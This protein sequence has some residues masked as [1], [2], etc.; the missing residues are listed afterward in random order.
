MKWYHSVKIASQEED[1]EHIIGI[2]NNGGGEHTISQRVAA[3][4][5][6]AE[7]GDNS[8]ATGR[9]IDAI[10]MDGDP[11][12]KSAA[13]Q[14]LSIIL[15]K[16]N[17][18]Q[19]REEVFSVFCN[20]SKTVYPRQFADAMDAVIASFP[21]DLHLLTQ[22]FK[23]LLAQY[24]KG[25][26]GDAANSVV[27]GAMNK[28][29]KADESSMRGLDKQLTQPTQKETIAQWNKMKNELIPGT[30]LKLKPRDSNASSVFMATL[31]TIEYQPFMM[32]NEKKM[33]PTLVIDSGTGSVE[34]IGVLN[35]QYDIYVVKNIE[36]MSLDKYKGHWV[37]T[38][39]PVARAFM[40]KSGISKGILM[41]K[42][43]DVCTIKML[44][45][46]TAWLADVPCSTVKPSVEAPAWGGEWF[47]KGTKFSPGDVVKVNGDGEWG[48]Y[49]VVEVYTNRKVNARPIGSTSG[50]IVLPMSKLEYVGRIGLKG[51][52][53]RNSHFESEQLPKPLQEQDGEL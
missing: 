53:V 18:N 15:G 40:D 16:T 13:I 44:N 8:R 25:D 23:T 46:T 1:L 10:E 24:E 42:K 19:L 38:N 48:E 17:N 5:D 9:L 3:A 49:L 33:M 11:Q 32:G 31:K 47:S 7:F 22:Q 27:R 37:Q 21:D 41:K 26:A 20:I 52:V 29:I 36:E 39:D 12:V 28:V 50:G 34:R 51:D 2:L 45:G 14:A 4:W 43:D 35:R 6:L 30:R